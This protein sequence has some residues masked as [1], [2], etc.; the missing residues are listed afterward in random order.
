[1]KKLFLFLATVLLVG[2]T[3][4]AIITEPVTLQGQKRTFNN[5]SYFSWVIRSVW[6]QASLIN[7]QGTNY[8]FNN[9]NLS[10]WNPVNVTSSVN[11]NVITG[12][13][14]TM[15]AQDATV[16]AAMTVFFFVM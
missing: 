9:V 8:T 15:P 11:C 10:N 4:Q 1:M 14:F 3:A 6:G 7:R 16:T 2:L 13:T 5:T 12:S